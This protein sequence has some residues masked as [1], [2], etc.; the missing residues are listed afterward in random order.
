MEKNLSEETYWERVAKTRMEKYLTQIETDFISKSIKPS[1]TCTVMDIGGEAG[2]FSSLA[3]DRNSKVIDIDIDSYGL[4]RLKLKIKN[5]N[6]IQA[7]ARKVSVKD[8]TF[9]VVFMIEVLDYIAELDEALMECHRT[10]KS[11]APL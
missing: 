4:K 1:Q 5:I 2:R 9:D 8:G 11:N 10:L 6:V 7:D 3:S